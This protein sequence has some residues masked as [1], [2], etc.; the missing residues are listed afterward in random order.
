MKYM[1]TTN[2]NELNLVENEYFEICPGIFNKIFWG[3]NSLFIT[4]ELIYI[5]DDI[6]RKSNVKFYH[7]N[8]FTYFNM[9][10]INK[11][12][13]EL[14]IRINEI[15]NKILFDV[16]Y[17]YLKKEIE[18]HRQEI[19]EMLNRLLSW[20]KLNKEN[21]ISIVKKIW[22]FRILRRNDLFINESAYLEFLPGK[23]E[24]KCFNDNSIFIEDGEL[25]IVDDLLCKFNK[26]YIRYGYEYFYDENILDKLVNEL[27]KRAN[28]IKL[29]GYV[30][31]GKTNK[32]YYSQINTHME[33]YKSEIIE[34]L[35]NFIEWIKMN[36]SNGITV[37]GI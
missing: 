1:V 27:E 11:F 21:G 34:M 15:N 32:K 18:E 25:D 9:E 2:K 6:I 33:L 7:F 36:K 3:E 30:V 19:I 22:N 4:D 14:S 20:I 28:Q 31:K 35:D 24:N 26:E 17:E 29:I 10:Q 23:Y 16:I 12:E 37:I 8:D 13:Y 5:I